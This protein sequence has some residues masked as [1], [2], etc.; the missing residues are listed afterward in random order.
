MKILHPSLLALAGSLLFWTADAR[1]FR[2]LHLRSTEQRLGL[3]DVGEKQNETLLKDGAAAAPSCKIFTQM[4][5]RIYYIRSR[6]DTVTDILGTI[7]YMPGHEW[8]VNTAVGTITP[9]NLTEVLCPFFAGPPSKTEATKD[10]AAKLG[11]PPGSP[12]LAF[13]QF[14]EQE[15]K[16][17][18]AENEKLQAVRSIFVDLLKGVEESLLNLYG[19]RECPL[20]KGEFKSRQMC[21]LHREEQSKALKMLQS[22][23]PAMRVRVYKLQSRVKA[24]NDQVSRECY[25][26]KSPKLEPLSDRKVDFCLN[27]TAVTDA[28]L[29]GRKHQKLWLKTLGDDLQRLGIMGMQMRNR[30]N[31]PILKQD[32]IPLNSLKALKE[33]WE[34]L[35]GPLQAMRMAG[36]KR[37]EHAGSVDGALLGLAGILKNVS[38]ENGCIAESFRLRY[39]ARSCKSLKAQLIATKAERE[40]DLKTLQ[41]ETDALLYSAS[42]GL[43]KKNCT[44]APQT[45]GC[46]LRLPT[47][48]KKIPKWE[49][50][51]RWTR[52]IFGEESTGSGQNSVVCLTSRKLQMDG[53]CGVM[54]TQT[55]FIPGAPPV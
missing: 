9:A 6:L 52:D 41:N 4:L 17:T 33:S 5:Q 32:K 29:D 14:V 18:N 1:S 20:E 47:G 44:A 50:A 34:A 3:E 13:L 22:D 55:R 38:T 48:C 53:M 26:E 28:I 25:I 46:W 40:R 37:A 16:G 12:Q 11:C 31:D 43:K 2:G 42:D 35:E 8:R 39:S 45:E 21:M 54:N 19:F 10:G 30:M 51:D 24:I 7:G 23:L 36:S 15:F 49:A 27:I